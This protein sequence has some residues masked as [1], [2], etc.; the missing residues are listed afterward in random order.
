[1]PAR[2]RRLRGPA[3]ELVTT[4]YEPWKSTARTASGKNLRLSVGF[5]ET[6]V[7]AGG[8]LEC[9]VELARIG[10]SGR[11]MLLAEIGLPPAVEVDRGSLEKARGSETGLY[12][13]DVLPDRVIAYVWPRKRETSFSF[14]F[15]PRLAMHAKSGPSRVYDYYNPDAAVVLPPESFVVR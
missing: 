12:Q 14:K 1:M 15:R 10:D 7:R 6:E 4:H 13:Y 8:E 5:S 11:G 2:R 9:T 3:A